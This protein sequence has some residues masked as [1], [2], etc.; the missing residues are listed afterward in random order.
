MCSLSIIFVLYKEL[1]KQCMD[2]LSRFF[3]KR[4]LSIIV[5]FL[6]FT[7]FEHPQYFLQQFRSWGDI[8]QDY[9]SFYLTEN[10]PFIFLNRK[11]WKKNM[12]HFL[13]LEHYIFCS[14]T[15]RIGIIIISAAG[16]IMI[17]SY[18]EHVAHIRLKRIKP[19]TSSQLL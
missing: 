9:L 13:N 17:F 18:K 6:S 19:K 11:P 8:Y 10:L 1:L 2:L 12:W 7:N 14:F 3:L 5:F 16:N 15:S 4:L